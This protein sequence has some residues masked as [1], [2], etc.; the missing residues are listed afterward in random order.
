MTDAEQTATKDESQSF[1]FKA[2]TKQ[3]LNI[4]IH[5]LYK[6]REVFLRELLS[7]ASDALNR[8]RF[9]MVTNQDIVDPQAELKIH[10]TVDK[11]SRMLTIQDTGIGMTRE[12]IIENLGTI[13]QSGA[14]KFIEATK[15]KSADLT[16]VI[17]QFGVGFYSV[18][19][20]AEW[21]RVTSRSYKPN[22]Q[23]VNWY[24]TGDDDYQ[25]SPAEMTERG[26]KVEI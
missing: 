22:E 4:L 3:L 2:E 1:H 6:D 8:L 5:S 13:A 12:E 16:Q 15:D 10:I 21:V 23:A 26:T 17:G 25:V 18:F 24:A 11:D 19:M 9:E 7:N 20:V 14:R